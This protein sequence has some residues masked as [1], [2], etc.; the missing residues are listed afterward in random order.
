M[1]NDEDCLSRELAHSTFRASFFR[2]HLTFFTSILGNHEKSAALLLHF[3][4][5]MGADDGSDSDSDVAFASMNFAGVN[6]D[7]DSA[8]LSE[9]D[10][11][12]LAV[13][14]RVLFSDFDDDTS[15]DERITEGI[16]KLCSLLSSGKYREVLM[17]PVADSFFG[18]ID[19]TLETNRM[20]E[21]IRDRVYSYAV[22]VSSCVQVELLAVAALDLFLQLNYT[23][24]SLDRGT[25]PTDDSPKEPLADIHPHA[26]FASRLDDAATEEETKGPPPKRD[27]KF[28][29][30]VLSELAVDGE[31]PC[32]VCEA[33]Y[34][35]LLA[36]S[37]LHT[38]AN[39]QRNDWTD[40][41]GSGG[42]DASLEAVPA[43]FCEAAANLRAVH[44]WNARAAVAHTRLLQTRDPPPTQWNEAKE[45]FKAALVH[46][47]E[48]VDISEGDSIDWDK[49][50]QAATV[51]LEWG[52]AHHY[53]NRPDQ[54]KLYFHKA[55]EY[56]G[57][58]V[59]VTGAIGKR[60]K[61]QQ[62]STAQMVVRATSMNQGVGSDNEEE[63]VKIKAQMVE[64][65]EDGILLEKIKFDDEK[66]NQISR[67]SVLDQAIL[68]A[69]CLD[70]KN[71]NPA[72][73]LTA[74]QMGAYLARVLDHHDDWMVYST[75]LLERAWL[76]CERVQGRERAI[77]QIQ[78]LADQHTNRLTITQ[79]T[80]ESI[81]DSAPAQDRLRNLHSIVYPPRWVILRDL[82]E[83]YAKIGIVTSAAELFEEVE[84]WDEVV[85]CYRHAGK[86]NKAEEIV[87]ERLVQTETPQ[88]WAALGDLT[89]DP[90]HYHKALELSSGRYSSAYVA[91]GKHYF[92]RGEI[93]QAANYY[94]NALK[95]RPLMPHVWFRVGTISMQLGRWKE[96][97]SAFSEV[98]QQ[99]PEEADA[100]A[101]VAAVHMHNKMPAEAF[102]ALNE[103]RLVSMNFFSFFTFSSY[104]FSLGHVS[105]GSQVQ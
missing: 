64:H 34:L 1:R 87:R 43:V 25:S 77:L 76:E 96:A 27:N 73:G 3:S 94:T 75:A 49:R 99:E 48:N 61:F 71:N 91:L 101:N 104:T 81:E 28:H 51:V 36:R 68:L 31:W 53:F 24:P 23:G 32:Q 103:V 26:C 66:E 9:S 17:S 67:L 100:W 63:T 15:Q 18:S 16:R 97:L 47:C 5:K 90:S 20:V 57:L 6:F 8:G 41:A 88:M 50:R 55:M 14:Q 70:V 82:A 54:G 93:E 98:V 22:S 42:N 80:F 33:P 19:S 83:R 45:S 69:H 102:P 11:Q 74:E 21:L 79:S 95:I 44:L 62:E 84:L 37:M 72:D 58:N 52:L 7:V 92:D 78:A 30:A 86:L 40:S 46:F 56:S 35:L 105:E 2:A 39:P 60:T 85:E 12:A 59:E 29:N 65:G 10:V 4:F 13:E 38:L 89:S